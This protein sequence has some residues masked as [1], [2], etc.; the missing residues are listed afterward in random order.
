MLKN[1]HNKL[2][3]LKT[4]GR[5][6]GFVYLRSTHCV[7]TVKKLDN[8]RQFQLTRWSTGNATAS[9][10]DVSW[11]WL[12]FLCS[13]LCFIVEV[14][15]FFV[16]N[17]VFVTKFRNYFCNVNFLSILN[18]LQCLSPIKRVSRY[19]PS[20]FNKKFNVSHEYI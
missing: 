4:C 6:L 18:I 20:T 15:L 11:F 14:L 19:R 3:L 17:A 10:Q 13:S 1:L 16:P 9:V 7:G 2:N 8:N 5:K 12:R